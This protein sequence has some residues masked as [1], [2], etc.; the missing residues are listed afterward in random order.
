MIEI[1][2]F[3]SLQAEIL[4][5]KRREQDHHL[6]ED[7]QSFLED[8]SRS[9]VARD[10]KTDAPATPLDANTDQTL[11]NVEIREAD[12]QESFITD[13]PEAC[14]LTTSSLPSVDA[15]QA[16][17]AEDA[18]ANLAELEDGELSDSAPISNSQGQRP[19]RNIIVKE[20]NTEEDDL[21][22]LD[23]PSA[24]SQLATGLASSRRE[25]LPI[26]F[27]V[28]STY[29]GRNASYKDTDSRADRSEEPRASTSTS[30][31]DSR[32]RPSRRASRREGR[33]ASRNRR[34]S[35]RTPRDR[36]ED[37]TSRSKRDDSPQSVRRRASSGRGEKR[38][39]SRRR[40]TKL[41][42]NK[43]RRRH[44]SYSSSSSG[45]SS[46]SGS[47]S[48]ASRS[49]SCSGS[50]SSFT[51]SRSRSSSPE[52]H[53]RHHHSRRAQSTH[54][55]TV[56]SAVPVP[57]QM[58]APV[59]LPTP[60]EEEF[61]R[62]QMSHLYRNMPSNPNELSV[63]AT[64]MYASSPPRHAQNNFS[65]PGQMDRGPPMQPPQ[66]MHMRG[67]AGG[68]FHP[69]RAQALASDSVATS[70]EPSPLHNGYGNG[71]HRN[72]PYGG[73]AMPQRPNGNGWP[74]PPAP[75]P[76]R[77]LGWPDDRPNRPQQRRPPPKQDFWDASGNGPAASSSGWGGSGGANGNGRGTKNVN[78][79]W[80]DSASKSD[81]WGDST[82]S[83]GN[84]WGGNSPAQSKS[85]L[86]ASQADPWGSPPTSVS[87]TGQAKSAH[88]SAPDKDKGDAQAEKSPW[89]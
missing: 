61:S 40:S 3:L 12:A 15:P 24:K 35:R 78:N 52:R 58:H 33:E 81:P 22:M 31:S 73:N 18:E 2:H 28:G 60:P 69:D 39:R 86:A 23:G 85:T 41:P 89:D 34:S 75:P 62:Q 49:P 50:S 9:D 46:L 26:S 59:I 64:S 63:R 4:F 88:V 45:S 72:G 14:N 6:L 42:S 11:H 43:K 10:S 57:M 19:P 53:R 25:S 70:Y 17:A 1:R 65:F 77:N 48:S 68:N 29:S 13:T 30:H 84:A 67:A 76:R 47:Y 38:S 80:G 32:R 87:I 83:A 21:I 5:F 82:S 55:P 71:N 51:S 79:G 44:R 7:E 56:Y 37:R 74:D 27:N 16:G 54:R 66:A 8:Q 20:E 36:R